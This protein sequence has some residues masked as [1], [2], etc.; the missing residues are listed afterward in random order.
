LLIFD[1]LVIADLL[2]VDYA[3]TGHWLVAAFNQQSPIDNQQR[4]NNQRSGNRQ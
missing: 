1:S 3:D 4:I 2:I